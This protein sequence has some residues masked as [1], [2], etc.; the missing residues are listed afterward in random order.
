MSF[1][2]TE[3]Q[4][5]L[6][7]TIRKFCLSEIAPRIQEYEEKE[8]FPRVIFEKLRDMSL[9]GMITP[10]KYGGAELDFSTYALVIEEISKYSLSIAVSLSV[11]GLPQNIINTFGNEEQK[12]T[13]VRD[14]ATG[15]K[16]GAFSLSEPGSGSDAAGLK[17]KAEHQGAQ[18]ILNGTKC[19]VTNGQEAETYLV[20]ARTGE[21]KTKGISAFIVE[22]GMGGFS[23]GKK[24]KKM[25]LQ[26]SPTLELIFKDC[27]VPEK[28]LVGKP[29]QGFAIAMQAL[30]CGRITIGAGSVGLAT[31]AFEEAREYAKTRTQFGSSLSQFQAI[32]MMLADMATSI[33][34]SRLLV[35]KAAFLKD[36]KL[37]FSK[38]ASMAKTVASD[39]A[40][41][42]TTKAV[43][44]FGGNGYCQDYPVER[45]MREAK[46]LQIVEGTNQ[47]Q[48]VVIAKEIL[49]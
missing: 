5:H 28:N 18:Y 32:Q 41:Q 21:D 15:K 40:M 7:E 47:I 19:F 49:K 11:T 36:Q 35:Q 6:Q 46:V 45:L 3:E 1:L 16:L 43:Q 2:L 10:E 8:E 17:T 34:Y 12:E 24:E 48:R 13:Y 39:T 29:G 26:S 42:V 38:I 37:P 31:R 20:F 9:T 14:L 44:I 27:A 22:K 30:D 23:F 25:A 4:K 33:E